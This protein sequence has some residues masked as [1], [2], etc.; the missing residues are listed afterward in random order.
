MPPTRTAPESATTLSQAGIT[1]FERGWLSSNSIF[2]Q[3]DGPTTLVDSGYVS[4][5]DQTVALV[6]AALGERPLDRLLNTHLHSDHCGGNAMLQAAYPGVQT[7]IPPGQADAVRQ[8]DTVALS[9]EPTG[10]SCPR[11]GYD[12]LLTPGDSVK[13]G[14]LHWDVHAAKG[15]DP[16]SIVLFQPGLRILISADA[17]WEN[18]FGVVFPELDGVSAFE[19]VGRT[20]DLIE[21]LE[22][23]TVIPGHGSVF[24]DLQGAL[25]RARSRLHQFTTH[26][27]KHQR[28]A[29]KVLIKFKLLEWQSITIDA[30]QQWVLQTPYFVRSL[31]HE[32][33]ANPVAAREWLGTLLGELEHARALRRDGS[34]IINC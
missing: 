20:L 19:E 4:H 23:A 9:Y 15:H 12:G 1:V 34:L 31:P 11:F 3:G 32:L 24:H 8:W 21:T 7:L 27:E 10:Q 13:L 33:S 6:A 25:Q 17:L 18:G 22:P 29:M 28:H 5:A 14:T 16:H 2:I 26:P 30:M